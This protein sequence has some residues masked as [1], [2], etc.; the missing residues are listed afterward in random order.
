MAR[1][2]EGAILAEPIHVE[3]VRAAL[4]EP[5]AMPW[6]APDAA[7]KTVLV[8]ESQPLTVEGVRSF[9]RANGEFKLMNA[10]DSLSIAFDLVRSRRPSIVVLDKSLGLPAVMDWIGTLRSRDPDTAVIVWG[11]SMSESEAL[12]LVQVGALGVIRKSVDPATFLECLRAVAAGRNWM[13][14]DLLHGADRN[15]RNSRSNLTPR[16]QQVVELVEQGL[17]NK[18]IAQEMGIRPGTV[19]IHLKHIFE[20][21]GVRG[22]FGL[23][24]AGLR[25]KGFLTYPAA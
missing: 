7:A 11:V 4:V 20:K 15:G 9:L 6:D 19:K 12:R 18:E 14:E 16:E 5:Q 17:K 24:L 22:R 13:E 1:H 23:A 8:C 21:T 10:V 2:I 3:T 25:E